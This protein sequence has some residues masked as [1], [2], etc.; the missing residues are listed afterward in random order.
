MASRTVLT[1]RL[2]VPMGRDG[3]ADTAGV[4]FEDTHAPTNCRARHS[5]ALLNVR[6]RGGPFPRRSRIQRIAGLYVAI[7]VIGVVGRLHS[8]GDKLR[9]VPGGLVRG[10]H[11]REGL[12]SRGYMG[13]FWRLRGGGKGEME[14][15]DI[16][17][18]KK[19]RAMKEHPDKAKNPEEKKK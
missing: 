18:V 7:V 1:E 12:H 15:Y 11:L 14:Y 5:D 8:W 10:D 4:D 3:T 19:E 17:G 9:I 13:A 2:G 16:L 6:T